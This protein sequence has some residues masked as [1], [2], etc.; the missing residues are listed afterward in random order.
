MNEELILELA[1]QYRKKYNHINEIR[2]LTKELGD[3]L[4][5][6]DKVSA[7][8]LL[9]MRGEE[10]AGADGC[11]KNI[12]LL[13]ENAGI[14]DRERLECLLSE[15]RASAPGEDLPARQKQLLMQIA[16]MKEKI[17]GILKET[18][19]IDKHVSRRLAGEE[20]FYKM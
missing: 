3:A 6:N 1:K 14:Q 9:A 17:K 16:D 19:S 13:I 2:R 5:R 18:V 15:N 12:R 20:S 8:L 10:M 4:A 7:Q 11:E